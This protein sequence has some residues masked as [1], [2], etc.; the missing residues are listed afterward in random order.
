VGRNPQWIEF[1]V[2]GQFF[3][4]GVFPS[5]VLEDMQQRFAHLR[6]QGAVGVIART[7]WEVI[8]DNEV[9][10]TL[11]MP[12]LTGYAALANGREIDTAEEIRRFVEGPFAA[13]L[14]GGLEAAGTSLEG[15]PRTRAALARALERS[16][17]MMSKAVFVLRHVFHEDCMFPDTLK[18]A[19][20]MLIEVHGIADWDQRMEG[21]LDL[22]AERLAE[23]FAE[24]DQ[25]VALAREMANDVA[26]ATDAETSAASE[27]LRDTYELQQWYVEGFSAC[28][29]ACF[30]VKWALMAPD[31][32]GRHRAART[33]LDA[34]EQYRTAL[35][36]RLAGTHYPHLVYWLLDTQRLLSL[37][38]DLEALLEGRV[39][40]VTV[41]A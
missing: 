13:A 23:I 15:A 33:E 21:A 20:M 40:P 7:D 38:G 24:K 29:K 26:E 25:A 27:Q 31:D 10:D 16:W 18:K 30:A 41:S 34:L 11:N 37:R 32:D 2:W 6:A 22:T 17:E 39:D 35:G 5:V 36:E 14:G 3:G 19:F 4:L 9:L 12:N 1:D 28:A 8:S